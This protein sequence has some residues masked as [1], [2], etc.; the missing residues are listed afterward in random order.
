MKSNAKEY[1]IEFASS[2][3]DWLKALI[4]SAIE[5]NG[6]IS[7]DRKTEIFKCLQD[8]T[9]IEYTIPNIVDSDSDAEI[10]LTKLVHKEG[11]NALTENQIIKFHDDITII[12]GLNGAGKSGYF[13][14]IN[15]IVG[16][17]QIKEILP[18]IYKDNPSEID[19]EISYKEF[20]NQT[21]VNWV[22]NSR[23]L[24]K[25]NKCK[26]FDTSY[27]NGLLETRQNDTTLIQPLGLN[28]FTYLIDL[29]DKFKNQ[30]GINADKKRI[31]KPNI[32]LTNISEE[33]QSVFQNHNLTETRKK[34]IIKLF[35]FSD[36]N[37]KKLEDLNK[38]IK[39]LKQ[40][41]IQDKIKILTDS[42]SS[43][44]NLKEWLTNNHRVLSECITE[45]KKLIDVKKEKQVANNQAKEQFDVLNSI[46]SSNT[47]EWK[48]FIIT[49]Q[50][51]S[52]TLENNEGVCPYCMQELQSDNSVKIL[53]AYGSFLQDNS[54]RELKQAVTILHSKLKEIEGLS[55]EYQIIE[56]TN[57]ILKE[58]HKNEKSLYD[59]VVL[60]INNYKNV[61]A[62]LVELINKE[63][64]NFKVSILDII[65]LT[66]ELNAIS[67]DLKIQIDNYSKEDS[68]KKEK[69][70]LIE[71]K[72]KNLKENQAIS[73][74]K[75]NI[76]KWMGL[77]VEESI[78]KKKANKINTRQLSSL[79]K[80]ANDDLLTE[81]LKV[82]FNEELAFIGYPNLDVKIENAGTRKGVSSTKLVLTRSN[83]IKSILS[84]G[85]Q[86]AVALA[87]FIAEVRMQKQKNPIALDDPVNSLDHKIAGKFAE[88]LLNLDNQIII[89]NHNRLFLDSF[90]TSKNN[91][92][93]KTTDTDCNKNQGKHIKVYEVIAQS[94]HMKGVLRNYKGNYAKNHIKDAKRLLN[95]IPFEDDTKVANLLRLSVECTI[96][97]VIFNHQV[98][99]RFSNKNSRIAWAELKNIKNGSEIVDSLERIH[100]RVS[101]GQMHNGTERNENPID[102]DEFNR[103]ITDIESILN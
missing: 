25:L 64:S 14:I 75:G 39:T 36:E 43:I 86:K 68:E 20:R 100:G 99:T 79:S 77:T 49:G 40:V 41:N 34:E 96:D 74:Q 63:D 5:T 57:S 97:E 7:S 33:I 6:S 4:Y 69:I 11:V 19:V 18:N 23:S 101:G 94:K 61:K 65:P 38:E 87:L 32:D 9:A 22:G 27:L 73:L 98:P 8:S 91:H 85:E 48:E 29:L 60:T 45:S 52:K 54:E 3:E 88:R 51:Y 16:G 2:Q 62:N 24:E 103:M 46:P 44:L 80:T 12:N 93:C 15:E 83:A 58:K 55:L 21:T 10:I 81:A 42:R 28:I 31:Q 50:A 67:E 53:Q 82:K 92:I 13:K 37:G 59:L 89:F 30:L 76:E 102:I 17:N 1:L 56:N 66:T 47:K 71:Q 90:E 70:R 95:Q 78:L 72:L 84:E 26:V 35:D